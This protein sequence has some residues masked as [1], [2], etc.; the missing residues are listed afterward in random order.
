MS[1]V[2][3]EMD[4]YDAAEAGGYDLWEW[5]KFLKLA[6]DLADTPVNRREATMDQGRPVIHYPAP[7]PAPLPPHEWMRAGP[8]DV[9]HPADLE[10]RYKCVHCRQTRRGERLRSVAGEYWYEP[11][12]S[13]EGC[14]V[15]LRPGKVS[16]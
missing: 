9:S 2:D 15:A 4:E 12:S 3:T 16:Q 13:L 7:A 10:G 6:P 5:R 1:D 11:P 14:K 8:D